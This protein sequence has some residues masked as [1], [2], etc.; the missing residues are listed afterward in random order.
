MT[1]QN[2][3]DGLV[4]LVTGGG[5]G[6]GEGI[7]QLFAEEGASVVIVDIGVSG[8]ERVATNIRKAGHAAIAI[9]ADVTKAADWQAAVD[10]TLGQYGKIDILVNN[11]GWTY[12]RKESLEVTEEEYDRVFDINVKGIFHSI[13]AV[14]PHFLKQGHGNIINISSCITCKPTSGLLYYGATKA[15]VDML[16]RGLAAEYSSRGIRVNG[17]SPSLGNTALVSQFVGEEFSGEMAKEQ[18]TQAPLQRMV[19][20][21]DIAKGCL[22][23][24]SP[25]FNDFQTG[26]TLRVDGG[27]Y[28]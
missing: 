3:L 22:Y 1:R 4:A 21:L 25:Y 27:Q 9:K 20:P 12:R 8:A 17:I 7:A 18:A 5:S 10:Q 6:F 15:A 24:A 28:C 2:Q 11:A 13:N 19:T 26:I 23:F 16:T 14:L